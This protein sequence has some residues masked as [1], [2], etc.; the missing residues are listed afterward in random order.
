MGG[1]AISLKHS[2]MDSRV[3]EIGR[4]LWQSQYVGLSAVIFGNKVKWFSFS[5]K[6]LI[7]PWGAKCQQRFLPNLVQ[8]LKMEKPRLKKRSVYNLFLLKQKHL[9]EV[10]Y[11]GC[12]SVIFF[13]SEDIQFNHTELN[14]MFRRFLSST[15]RR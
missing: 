15:A 10:L 1:Y 8:W 3:A 7:A 14:V 5:T 4:M 9:R 2:C 13:S 12:I 6:L 11:L